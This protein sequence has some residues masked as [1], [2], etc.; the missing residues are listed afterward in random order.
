MKEREQ[1]FKDRLRIEL[2]YNSISVKELSHKTNIA[3]STLL[4]YLSKDSCI[5]NAEIAVKIAKAL[6]VTVEY[7]VTGFDPEITLK[8]NPCI[9][10]FLSL[11]EPTRKGLQ[12]LISILY[13]DNN[14]N[15]VRSS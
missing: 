8:T 4:K 15:N 9:E 3:Y 6:N 2:Y 13:D 1:S 12:N 11:P 5:P 10:R 14:K 7:L